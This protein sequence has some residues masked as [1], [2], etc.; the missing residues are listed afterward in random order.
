MC[1]CVCVCVTV[2]T[3]GVGLVKG[4]KS[5]YVH[6]IQEMAVLCVTHAPTDEHIQFINHLSLHLHEHIT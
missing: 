3:R 6:D 4:C 5:V 1:V 2:C